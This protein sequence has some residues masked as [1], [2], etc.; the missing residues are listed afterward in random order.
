MLSTTVFN[1]RWYVAATIKQLSLLD[2]IL[3]FFPTDCRAVSTKW[4]QSAMSK[5]WLHKTDQ[6]F[7]LLTYRIF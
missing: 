1:R 4:V 7:L 5:G 3:D 2:E 6:E